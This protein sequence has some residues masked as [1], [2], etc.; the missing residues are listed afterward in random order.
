MRDQEPPPA[1]RDHLAVCLRTWRGKYGQQ[2]IQAGMKDL[3]ARLR[4]QSGDDFDLAIKEYL[5][6][7]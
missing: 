3:D 2:E 7:R 4:G 5:A 1:Q 6:G